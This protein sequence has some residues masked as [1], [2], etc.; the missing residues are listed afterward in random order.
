[1]EKATSHWRRQQR[2]DLD[3]AFYRLGYKGRSRRFQ[4]ASIE[5]ATAHYKHYSMKMALYPLRGS[6]RVDLHQRVVRGLRRGENDIWKA[7]R[8]M[9]DYFDY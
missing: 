1:M 6:W 8:C 5:K 3:F 7:D 9:T 2:I 4:Q